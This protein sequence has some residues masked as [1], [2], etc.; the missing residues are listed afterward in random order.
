MGKE[1]GYQHAVKSEWC[2]TFL[3]RISSLQKEIKNIAQG[4]IQVKTKQRSCCVALR[5]VGQ[6]VYCDVVW[7]VSTYGSPDSQQGSGVLAG[8]K[9]F[10]QGFFKQ[11]V[12]RVVG[13][14]DVQIMSGFVLIKEGKEIDKVA[15]VK[16]NELQT[17]IENHRL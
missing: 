16:K 5:W 1:K 2:M 12:Q 4:T 11:F 10:K 13:Q 3:D 9:Q 14:F 17:K 15:G 8:S 6:T 7:T